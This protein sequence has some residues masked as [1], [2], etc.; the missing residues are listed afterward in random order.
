MTTKNIS[1]A[2]P[3][4]KNFTNKVSYGLYTKDATG[5]ERNHLIKK[6]S[7]PLDPRYI[8]QTSSGRLEVIG[9]ID[10]NHP[11]TWNPTHPNLDMNRYM[12][13]SGIEGNHPKDLN[14]LPVEVKE[15]IKLAL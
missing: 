5:E 2:S 8:H 7:N 1:G 4:Y 10:Q 12:Y 14:S 3:T 11:K 6:Y 13:D 15:K 9:P